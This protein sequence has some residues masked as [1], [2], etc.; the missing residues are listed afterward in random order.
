MQEKIDLFS[1]GSTKICSEIW[2][3]MKNMVKVLNCFYLCF[4]NV[5][6]VRL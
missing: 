4:L 2:S 6:C 1:L 5:T 3:L